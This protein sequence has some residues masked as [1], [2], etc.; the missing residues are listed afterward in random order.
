MIDIHPVSEQPLILEIESTKRHL[1]AHT[2]YFLA[3]YMSATVAISQTGP[4]ELPHI[5]LP[6]IDDNFDIQAALER[7][8]LSPF[9]GA[10]L[11]NP[12]PDLT[13]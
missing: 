4:F 6:F 1:I 7:V 13:S 3:T 2:T 8:R 5:L 12:Y 11:E 9:N 10:T